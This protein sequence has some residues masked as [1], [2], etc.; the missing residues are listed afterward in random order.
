MNKGVS[1]KL[2]DKYFKVN[3]SKIITSTFEKQLRQ[4]IEETSEQHMLT[5]EQWERL[6]STICTSASGN[7][8]AVSKK[9]LK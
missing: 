6:R 7:Y 8:A 9:E 1:R 3:T 5:E 2:F 4:F